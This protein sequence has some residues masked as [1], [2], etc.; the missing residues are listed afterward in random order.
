M[1]WL[2]IDKKSDNKIPYTI[3]FIVFKVKIINYTPGNILVV[4]SFS[5][6]SKGETHVIS[7]YT[8]SYM[9]NMYD[10]RSRK[11]KKYCWKGLG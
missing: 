4:I 8:Y 11:G 10:S 6:Q 7:H 9:G 3:D 1:D 2:I 5:R